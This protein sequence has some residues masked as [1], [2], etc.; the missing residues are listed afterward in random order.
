MRKDIANY[1]WG[2]G[3]VAHASAEGVRVV[4]AGRLMSSRVERRRLPRTKAA[5]AYT[6][7]PAYEAANAV[8]DLTL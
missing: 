8:F 7:N 3:T 6:S 4:P 1:N 2:N 5:P